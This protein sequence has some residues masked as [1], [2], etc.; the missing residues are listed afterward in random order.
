MTH[1][2][3]TS[4]DATSGNFKRHKSNCFNTTILKNTF[5]IKHWVGSGA[6]QIRGTI[7]RIDRTSVVCRSFGLGNLTARHAVLPPMFR[8]MRL[9]TLMSLVIW[10]IICGGFSSFSA[11][12]QNLIGD[13]DGN[14]VVNLND[15]RTIARFLTHQIPT[16][17]NF[18]NA[19][20][21]QD[22]VID[23]Q[24]AFAIAQRV[25]GKTA[26][27]VAA[28]R[29]GTTSA[30][31]IGKMI[32]IQAFEKFAPF[33]VT[34]ASVRIQSAT[35]AYDSGNQA[36]VFDTDGRSLYYDWNTTGLTVANDY[37]INVT[38]N[39]QTGTTGYLPNPSPPPVPI[40]PEP[41]TLG[42]TTNVYEPPI[43]TQVVDAS[44]QTPGI[45]LVFRRTMSHNSA[46]YPYLGPFGYGWVH[47]YDL[48][49]E[50]YTD[51]T[52]AFHRLFTPVSGGTYNSGP[53]DFGVL[54]RDPSGVFQLS[55][56]NGLIYRFLTNLKL[57]FIQDLHGNKVKMTYDGS[58]H[59]VQI[60]HSC[61]KSFTLQYNSNGY[62]SSLT[63]DVGRITTYQ[64]MPT[65]F[66]VTNVVP[67]VPVYGSDN[68]YYLN[69]VI[70]VNGYNGS[71]MLKAT[72]PVGS[73]TQYTYNTGQSGTLNYTL[74]SVA[75]ADGTFDQFSY[76]SNAR[77]IQKT[78]AWGA[79]PI[80]YNYATNGT[81]ISD[82]VGAGTLIQVDQYIDVLASLDPNNG[83]TLNTYD[84]SRNLTQQI[85][86][87]GNTTH[88]GYNEFGDLT[89]STDPLGDVVQVGYNLSFHKPVW[90]IDPL[91]NTNS[92]QY[93]AVGNLLQ[94]THPDG[95]ADSF[96]CDPYGNRVSSVDPLGNTN[97][98]AFNLQGLLTFKFSRQ[99]ARLW[100][101]AD[102]RYAGPLDQAN[103]P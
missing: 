65:G 33:N 77:L 40:Q 81:L 70:Q 95:T 6:V 23:M 99:S 50:E 82:A 44:C 46:Y 9:G 37:T 27:V 29:Y 1:C 7:M 14:G 102:S 83:L 20:V 38:L 8:T 85:D 17:P 57:D 59:L 47:N 58:N 76:D 3:N 39:E 45:P 96:T 66:V 22:G 79:D 5:Q 41:V 4:K 54:T 12:A 13:A 43:L 91:G 92:F 56:K 94:V 49:L 28:P 75:Y 10:L 15:A 73:V 89:Q 42:L 88:F 84:G 32:H 86:P 53:G 62:I 52:V 16:I 30:L 87:R 26:F 31:K 61:G 21:N 68:V 2:L 100:P 34:G 55:E 103:L 90:M 24:D 69:G 48:S 11:K 97:Q 36:M 63:D 67:G 19:D 51:G 64:Y 72:D 78:G 18:T 25:T 35:A 71:L 60:Q 74:T 93:D 80:N 101:Y 98:F